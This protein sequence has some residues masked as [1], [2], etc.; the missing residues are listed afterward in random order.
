M[1]ISKAVTVRG[2]TGN[3]D[4]VILDCGAGNRKCFNVSG[5]G[6]AVI[7]DLTIRNPKCGQG[8]VN[9]DR[10]GPIINCRITDCVENYGSQNSRWIGGG[11]N[12][13]VTVKD[14]LIDG[15][16]G[17][18]AG[19][20]LGAYG[21]YRSGQLFSAIYVQGNGSVIEGCVITNN[22]QYGCYS[23]GRFA[24]GIT[25]LKQATISNC[26]IAYNTI[27]SI[28]PYAN[29]T[30]YALR[31]D[32]AATVISD[33][34]VHNNFYWGAAQDPSLYHPLRIQGSAEGINEYNNGPLYPAAEG[35]VVNVPGDYPTLADA[36]AAAN[37]YD[38]IVMA[39]GTHS[40]PAK[41]DVE[42]PVVI[43][44]ATGNR[45]DV[46]IDGNNASFIRV[47]TDGAAIRDLTL[48]RFYGEY[49]TQ[50]QSPIGLFGAGEAVNCRI[51]ATK[52]GGRGMKGIRNYNGKVVNCRIDGCDWRDSYAGD[53]VN[54]QGI[55]WQ[56]GALALADRLSIVDNRLYDVYEGGNANYRAAPLFITGGTVRNALVSGNRIEYKTAN[57]TTETTIQPNRKALGV[58]M[59]GGL[60]E[61]S[62][63]TDNISFGIPQD[64]VG[65][66]VNDGGTV[67]NCLIWGNGD[68][69]GAKTVN[70]TGSAGNFSYCATTGAGEMEGG[71][72]PE[73]IPYQYVDGIPMLLSGTRL[74]DGGAP[75]PWMAEATDLI[76]NPRLSGGKT[77]IGAT[78]F[79]SEM[80]V[81]WDA[82]KYRAYEHY[83][84]K[85]EAGQVT[86][87]T[88]GLE[89]LWDLDGD[90]IFEKSGAQQKIILGTPGEHIV[91]LKVRNAAG[92][93]ATCS[94]T[95]TILARRDVPVSAEDDLV[96]AVKAATDG[97]RLIVAA[98]TYAISE[99]LNLTNEVVIS[100]AT[101]N[102]D[103]VI[104][105]AGNVNG[106]RCAWIGTE[107]AGAENVTFTRGFT[108]GRA[109]GVYNKGLLKNCRI[110]NCR[111]QSQGGDDAERNN[112]LYP[113]SA[114]FN[115]GGTV[116]DCLIDGNTL[117]SRYGNNGQ[118]EGIGVYQS[119]GLMDRC[120]ITNNHTGS[121]FGAQPWDIAGG[122]Y[123]EGG[124]VR[125]CLI[126]WNG[127]D[128]LV[129]YWDNHK[130]ASGAYVTGGL[131]INNTVIGNRL[132][133]PESTKVCTY[134]SLFVEGDG[135]V[136]NSLIDNELAPSGDE[137]SFINCHMESGSYLVRPDGRIRIPSSSPC[138]NG[139]ANGTWME[140]ATD[141]YGS[142]RLFG[143]KVDIGC[144][145]SKMQRGSLL[146]I[147]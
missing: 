59:T 142:P 65:G 17:D 112:G 64:N 91:T 41:L 24:I 70:W 124:T 136:K 146:T 92:D 140:E 103:D 88:T 16:R 60:L 12:I 18:T 114:L 73:A 80:S 104:I 55:Y 34:S 23:D 132:T 93:E 42:K 54:G 45:D 5:T 101:G 144:V 94:R 20:L 38:E 76:G 46:I 84:E 39:A 13:A 61:S 147:H 122:V 106:R 118:H 14:C 96:A 56:A 31:S 79:V 37:P 120:V 58:Y 75:A 145:E 78:Q 21:S 119:A 10:N 71:I 135:V 3:R 99:T 89:Y 130:Y 69:D 98:G 74:I 33:V 87:D 47:W 44:G 1:T 100:G 35:A 126:G 117:E 68:S 51:T 97:D 115:D 53:G 113:H 109:F 8:A 110:T 7:R 57:V 26:L 131:F 72:T 43:R 83:E 50:M 30:G 143:S 95:F 141:L 134:A 138:Y 105:D 125:N 123:Q 29:D 108:V 27:H 102:R 6:G 40:L 82:A 77:G 11:N 62:T 52:S 81:T 133:L 116:L 48:S 67:R 22:H 121:S 86:G 66:V 19:N 127:I 137:A 139:G 36:Y 128:K 111:M 2:A 9:F 90:G 4:D 25:S 85:V 107:Y 129:I 32:N 28:A 15:N 49:W 63:I